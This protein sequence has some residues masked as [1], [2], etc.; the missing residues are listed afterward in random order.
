MPAGRQA[1]TSSTTK[2]VGHRP[3]LLKGLI[4]KRPKNELLVALEPPVLAFGG[5]L[6]KR[7]LIEPT[8]K[9]TDSRNSSL[10][11]LPERM[12]GN[13]LPSGDGNLSVQSLPGRPRDAEVFSLQQRL[14]GEPGPQEL[15]T[16]VDSLVAILEVVDEEHSL[17]AMNSLKQLAASPDPERARLGL[18]GLAR[19]AHAPLEDLPNR[20]SANEALTGLLRPRNAAIAR[21]RA[22]ALCEQARAG[23]RPCLLALAHATQDPASGP[24]VQASLH[25]LLDFVDRSEGD[26]RRSGMGA[27]ALAA[28]LDD[29][30]QG[31]IRSK[32]LARFESLALDEEAVGRDDALQEIDRLALARSNPRL[33]TEA[34]LVLAGLGRI[35]LPESIASSGVSR[36]RSSSTEALLL[37]A[38]SRPPLRSDEMF[39]VGELPPVGSARW[40]YL[41]DPHNWHPERQK[42]HQEL[43]TDALQKA[44]LFA[45]AIERTG[46]EPTLFALRGNTASG[47]TRM[48]NSS[49]PALAEAIEESGGGCVNPDLFKVRLAKV[50]GQPELTSASV[51]AESCVLADRLER[52]L[53]G[54][55]TASG[56]PASMLVDKRL[57]GAHEVAAYMQLAQ[58]TGRKVE[59]FDIDAPLERSLLG[60]LQRKPG[61]A[62]P[63][64]PYAAVSAGFSAVRGNR[65][66]VID[67][68]LAN[69][70]LGT[71]HL[72]GTSATGAKMPVATVTGGELMIHDP[73]AYAEIMDPAS[74]LPGNVGDRKIDNETIKQLTEGMPPTVAANAREALQ[75]YVGM[76]WY[77]AL[78]AHSALT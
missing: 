54:L 9:L 45:E 42:L 37:V 4:P 27:L 2:W 28:R 52:E 38:A 3:N 14:V 30:P 73:Q 72:Y 76:S 56:K 23:A 53:G 60:V 36:S 50:P 70:T 15:R 17:E 46:R 8:P 77:D 1:P 61:G 33:S 47:K 40:E 74:S 64:P 13:I 34:T 62:D 68:F 22:T 75:P 44:S 10:V 29:K 71:Y 31:P 21:Q 43:I 7:G 39:A 35:P 63:R 58:E 55:K 24:G 67:Q 26:L 19:L 25:A 6:E 69:P 20:R 59:L 49:M 66:Q 16:V 18:E 12:R 5:L 51:H 41:D 78:R 48:A 11:S 32:V 57:G 65:L